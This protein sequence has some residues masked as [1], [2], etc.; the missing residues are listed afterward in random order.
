MLHLALTTGGVAV[1]VAISAIPQARSIIKG[2]WDWLKG[3]FAK[4]PAS[5]PW[6][7]RFGFRRKDRKGRSVEWEISFER[8]AAPIHHTDLLK[9][10]PPAVGCERL[11]VPTYVSK[12]PVV[13]FQ[14]PAPAPDTNHRVQRAD[15]NVKR[16]AHK[17]TTA[18]K[19]VASQRNTPRRKKAA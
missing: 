11:D 4:H 18:G 6:R 7:F 1:F 16:P 12:M 14:L 9:T 2:S 5:S 13:T 17:R 19:Q 8:D 10:L 15:S 3:L